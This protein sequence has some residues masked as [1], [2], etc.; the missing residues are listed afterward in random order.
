MGGRGASSGLTSNSP[1][2][3]RLLKT[4]Q[5]NQAQT[6]PDWQHKGDYDNNGNPALIK[7]QQQEDDKTA[8]FLASTDRNVDLNDPQYDDGYSYHDIPLNMLLCFSS[9]ATSRSSAAVP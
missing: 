9:R 8:N 7:Y 6:G 5:N 1:S 2:L 3:N 4:I